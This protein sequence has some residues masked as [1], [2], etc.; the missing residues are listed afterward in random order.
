VEN[1]SRSFCC[2]E[3][4]NALLL[5]PKHRSVSLDRQLQI[6]QNDFGKYNAVDKSRMLQLML[7]QQNAEEI[8]CFWESRLRAALPTLISI[9]A[10]P[11]QPLS[12]RAATD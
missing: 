10:L 9:H 6:T 2:A 5:L 8:W 4:P 11:S 7:Q 3:L 12:I 1:E